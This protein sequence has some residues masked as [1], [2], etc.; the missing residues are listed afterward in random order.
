M[1]LQE[2]EKNNRFL[3]YQIKDLERQVEQLMEQKNQLEQ[4]MCFLP[5]NPVHYTTGNSERLDS[6][7]RK[8]GVDE[9]PLE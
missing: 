4:C 8:F 7:T 9:Y 6:L 2:L 1:T 5:G 3:R